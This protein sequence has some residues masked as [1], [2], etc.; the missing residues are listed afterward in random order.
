MYKNFFSK[1]WRKAAILL[2]SITFMFGLESYAQHIKIQYTDAPLKEVL[3]EI[4]RQS[5]YSFAY[6]DAFSK[7]AEGKVSCDLQTEGKIK[8]AIESTLRTFPSPCFI[9]FGK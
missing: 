5:G 2:L 9:I 3:K 1:K 8:A 4:T 6:S 7:Y